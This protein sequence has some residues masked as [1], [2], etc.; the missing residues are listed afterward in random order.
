MPSEQ[1][2]FY[3]GV[4]DPND[5]EWFFDNPYMLAYYDHETGEI[6]VGLACHDEDD[7]VRWLICATIHEMLH[8]TLR[9]LPMCWHFIH[10]DR[11]VAG[12]FALISWVYGP[13]YSVR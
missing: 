5:D 8:H 12:E 3:V 10:H 13:N 1:A 11:I 4:F 2:S 7:I 6:G 9:D